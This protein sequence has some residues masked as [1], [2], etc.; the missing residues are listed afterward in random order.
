[1]YTPPELRSF[2]LDYMQ[3]HNFQFSPKE[4]FEPVDYILQLGGKRLRP[5]LLLM[6]HNLYQ[7]KIDAALPAAYSYEI[8]HN[9]S[10]VHDDIMDEAP[11]RR[12][13]PTIHQKYDINTG[14]LSGDVMLIYAYR[15]LLEVP[16]KNLVPELMS[17]FSKVAS[18]VCIGQQYDMNFETSTTVTIAAYL[19]MIE[20]KTA[21]LIAGALQTGTILAGAPAAD[22]HHIYEFGRNLGIAFQ[23]QDDILDTYGNAATF[24]K[25]IGGDIVQNKKTYL[26][27]KAMQLANNTQKQVLEE[28]LSSYPK[29]ETAKIA[30]VVAIFDALDIK[31]IAS[32]KKDG[33]HQKAIEHLALVKVAEERKIHLKEIAKE[34]LERMK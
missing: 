20:Y 12:G 2:F 16:D 29:D 10:L 11:L 28:L 24:G 5:I 30:A 7:A 26:V 9:F 22:R 21:S 18:E 3:Q 1:M 25:R 33:Y 4:L 8:F 14:I 6:S 32:R 31:S 13:K 27:L 34:L 19:Q 17:L 15:Y 23:L